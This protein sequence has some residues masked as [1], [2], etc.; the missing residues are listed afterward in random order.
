MS[1][2][3]PQSQAV[4][5]ALYASG[6]L[7]FRQRAPAE[8]RGRM[9][10]LRA[11]T[12]E[13]ARRPMSDVFEEAVPSKHG[14]FRVRVLRPRPAA[15]GERMPVVIYFHGGGFFM[16]GIDE[17]DGLA[18]E[19][20]ASADVL[21]VNV[22]YALSPEAKFPVA[23]EQSYDAL[24]WVAANAPR[25]GAD[26]DR[27]A[28][29]GES[30]GGNLVMVVALI[31]RERHGPKV[32]FQVPIYP[33]VDYRPNV[34]YASRRELGGGDLILDMQ[35][36]A[37]MLDHYLEDSGQGEDWRASPILAATY[38]GLP[39]ALVVTADHDPLKDEGA[40]YAERLRMDGVPVEHVCFEGTFHG[41]IGFGASVEAGRQGIALVCDRIRQ[42]VWSVR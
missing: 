3:D 28:L 16:G 33:S 12:P 9:L 26:A 19:I 13:S 22:E 27:I 25:L 2:L 39:P 41:F 20:A 8:T 21:V 36:I 37:W 42:A 35:D 30:A 40:H 24:R 31:T 34:P 10:A 5:D 11:A 32:C 4:V 18:Q 15:A 38:S 23:V 1:N 7:P 29:A 17:T 14:D 6:L